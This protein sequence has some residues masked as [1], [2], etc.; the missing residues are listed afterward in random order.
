MSEQKQHP[1]SR[2]DL[3]FFLDFMDRRLRTLD[4]KELETRKRILRLDLE[5]QQDGWLCFSFEEQEDKGWRQ[6]MVRLRSITNR[7]MKRASPLMQ[8]TRA[9]ARLEQL[10]EEIQM[11]I[12]RHLRMMDRL[13]E[14]K[15]L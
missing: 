2:E 7:R 11:R 9:Y 10:R 12:D 1:L 14:E 13:L 3:M 4:E 8:Q 5:Y 6:S 15:G